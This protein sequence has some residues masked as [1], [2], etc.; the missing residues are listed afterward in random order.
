MSFRQPCEACISHAAGWNHGAALFLR[1]QPSG[2]KLFNSGRHPAWAAAAGTARVRRGSGFRIFYWFEVA[3]FDLA[4]LFLCLWF[5]LHVTFHLFVV[6]CRSDVISVPSLMYC[7][8]CCDRLHKKFG[9]SA[10]PRISQRGSAA[11]ENV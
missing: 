10:E 5:V 6:C 7:V 11:T 3:D 2:P 1:N 8:K 4:F 9:F